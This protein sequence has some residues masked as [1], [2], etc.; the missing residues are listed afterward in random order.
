MNYRRL[1]FGGLG[2]LIVAAVVATGGRL[3]GPLSVAPLVAL[4]END[5]FFLAVLGGIALAV[6]SVVLTRGD[7]VSEAQMP[8]AE[9]TVSVP[10]PGDRFDDRVG[11]WR[12][13]V[14][15]AG[16]RTRRAVRERLREDAVETLRRTRGY[17][18]AEAEARVREG[19]WTDDERA[20]AFLAEDADAEGEWLAATLRGD[21]P[22]AVR[23]RRTVDEITALA[24]GE[25][26]R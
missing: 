26:R 14:P 15:F 25:G 12:H 3:P 22:F 4:L 16:R 19:R 13:V 2:T 6:A 1:L 7:G 5:Y 8:E 17:G 18:A 10:T 20:A 24:D 9:E 21:P 23:A 11:R